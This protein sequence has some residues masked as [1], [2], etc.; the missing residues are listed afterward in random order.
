MWIL[1]LPFNMEPTAHFGNIM[2]ILIYLSFILQL[3]FQINPKTRTLHL[4]F[5]L[6]SRSPVLPSSTNPK[7]YS[8]LSESL[9]VSAMWSSSWRCIWPGIR[10]QSMCTIWS[11]F[12]SRGTRT[13]RTSL[14]AHSATHY[15]V[16]MVLMLGVD[17]VW[18]GK[19][20]HRQNI[21]EYEE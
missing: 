6:K 12:D 9:S 16:D 20:K 2:H 15:V 19:V 1:N 14:F 10:V 13:T 18:R 21:L 5:Y 11:F 3:H 17:V 8:L 4:R 7:R